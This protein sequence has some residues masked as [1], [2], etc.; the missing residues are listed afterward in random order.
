[1]KK[2]KDMMTEAGDVY[3]VREQILPEAI[4]KTIRVKALLERGEARTINDAVK[5]M[6]LSRSAYYKYKDHVAPFYVSNRNRSIT[7]AIRLEHRKG[8]LAKV[9]AEI[10]EAGGN[11]MTINQSVPSQGVANVSVSFETVRLST[12]LE[13]LVGKLRQLRGVKRLDIVAQ[14]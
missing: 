9:L 2:E 11:V 12:E 13:E 1:M 4:K 6:N 10:S 7:L 14:G 3:L 8:V 5:Q